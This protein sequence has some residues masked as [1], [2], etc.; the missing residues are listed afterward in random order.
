MRSLAVKRQQPGIATTASNIVQTPQGDLRLMLARRLEDAA[1]RTERDPVNGAE[2]V[3]EE[4]VAI[5]RWAAGYLRRPAMR[6][7]D[8][9][10]TL[11]V[12]RRVLPNFDA[13]L[14]KEDV[15]L[16]QPGARPRSRD[17]RHLRLAAVKKART[18]ES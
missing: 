5:L 16:L 13:L 18:Q 2:F 14:A 6:D 8:L 11:P 7:S 9:A 17:R 1:D 10:G 15:S 4:A 12:F 3:A